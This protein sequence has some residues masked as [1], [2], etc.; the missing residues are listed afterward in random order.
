MKLG[1]NKTLMDIDKGHFQFVM[2][3]QIQPEN[4]D[5]TIDHNNDS[6]NVSI[7]TDGHL[8]GHYGH[9]L[10]PFKDKFTV[11][12]VENRISYICKQSHLSM[13]ETELKSLAEEAY[14]KLIELVRDNA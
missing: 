1:N 11:G 4:L 3:W 6:V 9:L 5:G 13:S 2:T 14:Q 7:S 10:F 8:H 12:L